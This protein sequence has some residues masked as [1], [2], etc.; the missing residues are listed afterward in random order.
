MQKCDAYINSGQLFLCNTSLPENVRQDV[1]RSSLLAQMA[2]DKTSHLSVA[3]WHNQYNNGLLRSQ[4]IRKSITTQH[5]RFNL[6][7]YSCSE[8]ILSFIVSPALKEACQQSLQNLGKP[9][10][11]AALTAWR[12]AIVKLANTDKHNQK[13]GLWLEFVYVESITHITTV[14]IL[15][16][17]VDCPTG[18]NWLN[19]KLSSKVPTAEIVVQTNL[20]QLKSSYDAIRKQVLTKLGEWPQKLTF[21]IETNQTDPSALSV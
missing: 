18:D 10:N 11:E 8:L 15:L 3:H 1:L 12:H 2:A 17:G 21:A 6:E 9:I 14:S 20:F 7:Q 13:L 5:S 16:E 19:E 4:W